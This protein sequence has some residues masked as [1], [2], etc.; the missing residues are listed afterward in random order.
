MVPV[1]HERAEGDHAGLDWVACEW[2]SIGIVE[3]HKTRAH[4]LDGVYD[5]RIGMVLILKE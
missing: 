1:R 3:G 4:K 5:D 2:R